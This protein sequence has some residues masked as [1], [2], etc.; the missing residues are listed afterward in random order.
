MIGARG[1]ETRIVDLA[2]KFQG[3]VKCIA[4]LRKRADISKEAFIAYYETRHAPLITR[5]LPDILE[6]RRNFIDL[7]GAFLFPGAAPIDF[8]VVTEIWFEDQAAYDRF[9][10]RSAEPDIAQQIAEDEEN[11]FDRSATRMF[12]VDE[13]ALPREG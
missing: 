13:R 2:E 10:A 1:R 8:D 3:M 5:L 11:L 4:L 9:V 7:D 6:Y 12:L